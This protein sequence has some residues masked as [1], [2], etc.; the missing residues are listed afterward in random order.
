MMIMMMIGRQ[1][2]GTVFQ[3][4]VARTVVG[5]VVEVLVAIVGCRSE[6]ITMMMMT[7]MIARDWSPVEESNGDDVDDMVVVGVEMNSQQS[8][9]Y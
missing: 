3:D 8:Q 6:M 2:E 7:M 9:Q 4:S 5:D 1:D